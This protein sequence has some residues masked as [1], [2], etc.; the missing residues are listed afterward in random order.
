MESIRNTNTQARIQARLERLE[1][2]NFGDCQ[3]V[4]DGVFEL[5]IH[6]GAGYR[7]YFGQVGNTI[8]LLLCGGDKSSQT[9]DIERAKIYWQEYKETHQ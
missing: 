4:G 9:R 7:I 1:D 2:G 5:R 6:F 3:S 8:V